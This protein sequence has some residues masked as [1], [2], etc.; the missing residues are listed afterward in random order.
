MRIALLG[1]GLQAQAIAYDIAQNPQVKELVIGDVDVNNAR[2]LIERLRG[3]RV[4]LH[5]T[6]TPVAV[7]ATSRPQVEKVIAGC[8]VVIGC[9][10]YRHNVLLTEAAIA[11]KACFVDL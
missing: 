10:S 2:S 8:Q 7:D 9:T 4:R 6:L 3:K 5:P 11:Q 1:A